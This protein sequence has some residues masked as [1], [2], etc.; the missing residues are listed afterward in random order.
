MKKKIINLSKAQLR[1][2][3]QKMIK[4]AINSPYMGQLDKTG[5]QTSLQRW[6]NEPPSATVTPEPI[7][8]AVSPA[9]A[10][11]PEKTMPGTPISKGSRAPMATPAPSPAPAATEPPQTKAMVLQGLQDA[12]EEQ[13]KAIMSILN[14]QKPP[15][16]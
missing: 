13:I 8:P 2:V 10:E 9:P 7:K 16:E 4:E 6:T 1:E 14:P 3:L 11:Q 5:R 12:S 15:Q